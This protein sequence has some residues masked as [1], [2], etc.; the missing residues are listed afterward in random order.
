MS[1]C[2]VSQG[3]LSGV[4]PAS[5]SW[6]G[7]QVL[8]VDPSN[9]GALRHEEHPHVRLVLVTMAALR[10]SHVLLPHHVV[11]AILF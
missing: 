10:A 9:T 11:L 6:P 3:L 4:L 8:V 7:S 1:S 5:L 2:I